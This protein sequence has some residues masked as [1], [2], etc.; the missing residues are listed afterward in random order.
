MDEHIASI[1]EE[2]D[3]FRAHAKPFLLAIGVYKYQATGPTKLTAAL[4][5]FIMSKLGEVVE[6]PEELT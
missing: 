1:T 4:R 6:V 5:C 3:G 2:C